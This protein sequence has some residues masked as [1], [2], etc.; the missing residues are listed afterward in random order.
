MLERGLD[1]EYKFVREFKPTINKTYGPFKMIR[2]IYRLAS[3]DVILLD[4]YYPE[5]YKPVYD[6]NVK[7]IQVWH[8]CG[9]FK[10]LDQ[11][12]GA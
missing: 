6:Q 4:D 9:A 1:K 8:A 12:V 11:Y 10:A 3:S 7:V 2:F 5:I